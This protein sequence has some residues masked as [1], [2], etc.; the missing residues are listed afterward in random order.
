MAT[1]DKYDANHCAVAD[2]LQANGGVMALYQ[3]AFETD[4]SP[5][6][7]VSADIVFGFS[8]LTADV[9]RRSGST[10]QYHVTTGY[11][12]DHRIPLLR[13]S[14]QEIRQGLQ[15]NGAKHI[16]AFFDENSRE[17]ARWHLS[18]QDMQENFRF[19][20]QKVLDEPW[21][22]LVIKPKLPRHLRSRLGPVAEMLN[23]A[24]ATGRCRVFD[25]GGFRGFHPPTAAALA[26]DIAVHGHLSAATAGVESALAG[27]PT[28]LLDTEGW[29]TSR[30]YELGVGKT[31]FTTWES[32]WSAC[33][34]SW[35]DT[36][37]STDMGDWS[38]MLDEIDP[39][40]DGRAAE[41]MGTYLHWLLESFK[42]GADRAVAMAD[43]AQRYGELWGHDKVTD[44]NWNTASAQ[45][46][47][48]GNT[49]SS[50]Q[51]VSSDINDRSRTTP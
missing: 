50:L 11:L 35:S 28:L 33:L 48:K 2:A 7:T 51:T 38:M 6:T 40:R 15:S 34:E 27:I 12:G 17:D 32:L 20:L 4:P 18:H 25:D 44:I 36:S 9:E 19:L 13:E 10:A 39:F 3:R 30:F 24:E 14:A 47:G 21:F 16:M 42:N 23:R 43:A 26:V 29:G 49:H 37:D 22:G 8:D 5:I 31:V 45:S 1:Q 41:R 46:D